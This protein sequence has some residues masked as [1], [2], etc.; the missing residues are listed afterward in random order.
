MQH[1]F[2]LN[3][4]RLYFSCGLTG[5]YKLDYYLLNNDN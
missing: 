2:S 3:N 1:Q 4:M 5:F